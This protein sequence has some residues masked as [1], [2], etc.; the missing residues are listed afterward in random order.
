MYHTFSEAVAILF[1]WALNAIAA[2]GLSWAG[3]IVTARWKRKA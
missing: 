3:I 1:P 2:N